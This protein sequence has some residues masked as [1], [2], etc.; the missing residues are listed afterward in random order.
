VPL[1]SSRSYSLSKHIDLSAGLRGVARRCRTDHRSG[2]CDDRQYHEA[3]QR[4][5]DCP[6]QNDPGLEPGYLEGLDLE[7]SALRW[8]QHWVPAMA[9]LLSHEYFNTHHAERLA[10]MKTE[11]RM[12]APGPD[13]LPPRARRWRSCA[14][15]VLVFG[16][17]SSPRFDLKRQRWSCSLRRRPTCSCPTC[18][19]VAASSG[20][21]E[22]VSADRAPRNASRALT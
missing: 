13:G 3:G 4:C 9:N 11:Q 20:G 15:L 10:P 17:T 16:G 12:W 8:S 5:D 19:Q 18:G 21:Q 7:G 22:T 2:R 1:R 14:Q 6:G